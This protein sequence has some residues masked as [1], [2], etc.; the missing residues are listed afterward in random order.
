MDDLVVSWLRCVFLGFVQLSLAHTC[1]MHGWMNAWAELLGFADRSFYQVHILLYIIS[2]FI[3]L[4]C[5]PCLVPR[6]FYAIP[7]LHIL[8]F[9]DFFHL[10]VTLGRTDDINGRGRCI[11]IVL[12]MPKL[13]KTITYFFGQKCT[14][15]ESLTRCVSI[16]FT[17]TSAAGLVE[18]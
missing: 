18:Q 16:I 1:L 10:L 8:Q 13:D 4:T 9:E 6:T 3:A 12:S 11:D 17:P 5:H 15:C 14:K 7:I 2:H